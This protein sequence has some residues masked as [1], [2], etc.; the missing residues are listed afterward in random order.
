MTSPVHPRVIPSQGFD[1][2]VPTASSHNEP[3]R[4]EMSVDPHL[5]I[6]KVSRRFIPFLIL[7]Y[8]L[9]YLDRVNIGFAAL[10]MNKDIGLSSTAFGFG[11]SI[12][13]LGYFLFEVPSN[14]IL[15]KTG[16][17]IWIARIM[18]SWGVLS[19]GHA[20]IWNDT[21]FYGLRFIFGIAEAGFFPGIILYLTYWFPAEVRARIIGMFMVAVPISSLIGAPLSSWILSVVGDGFWGLKGWQW[22]FIVEGL[23]TF[24]TGFIVLAYLTDGPK[25]ATWLNAEERSWL[26]QRLAAERANK[27]AIHHFT[28]KEALTHPRVLALALVYFGIVIGLYSLG[29]WLPQIVKNFG[30]TIMQTGFLTAVPGLVGAIGMILWTRHSDVTGERKWHMII[31][32]VLGGIAL[33]A[34]A[35]V[36]SPAVSY[37]FL[38]LAGGCIYTA[39]P[40]FWPLPT[41]ILSGA[42]AAGGIALINALGNLGGFVGPFFVGWLKDLTGTFSSGL[43]G[44]AGFMILSGLI[45][46]ILGHDTRLER[47]AAPLHEAP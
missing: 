12:F 8:F 46:L 7:C 31:P 44:L 23:P 45:V 17:R 18:I 27:E 14:L 41:A 47:A 33:A 20:F 2:V 32:S 21:S 30:A 43:Y 9:S 11:A 4:G 15:E 25:D 42:A 37:I 19:I 16:A 35:S 5:V 13:F 38:T 39:L 1:A 28:L 3:T 22:M 10:T 24:I 36:A 34:S 29:L 40:C 6:A 26:V